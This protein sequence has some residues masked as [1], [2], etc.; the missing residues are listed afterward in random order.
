MIEAQLSTLNKLRTNSANTSGP[1]HPL[2]AGM[3]IASYISFG[4]DS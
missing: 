4:K 3:T 2:S 1:E